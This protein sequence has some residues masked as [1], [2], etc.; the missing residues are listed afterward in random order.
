MYRKGWGQATYGQ[1]IG[2]IMQSDLMAR[3]PGDIGNASTFCFPVRYKIVRDVSGEMTVR[4]NVVEYADRFIAAAKELEEEGV[5]AITTGCGRLSVL[6]RELS[7]AVNIPVFTSSLIQVPLIHAMMPAGQRIAVITADPS[8]LSEDHFDGVGWSAKD[9]P[10]VITGVHD[11]EDF[12]QLGNAE[13]ISE[14]SVK[15]AESGVIQVVSQ[16]VAE[17]PDV[18]SIVFECTN[19]P[20]FAAAVQQATQ[21][22]VF[23]I[24]TLTNMVYNAVVRRGYQGFL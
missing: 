1:A 5:R 7:G 13:R 11:N 9:I 21:L 6:Q 22:P 23:D 3:I 10:V 17:N 20:P 2:I 15:Q 24:V 18:G 16:L 19:L 8:T 12:S 4:P 14:Q